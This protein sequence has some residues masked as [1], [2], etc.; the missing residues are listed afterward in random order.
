MATDQRE[1]ATESFIRKC[2]A[3][4]ASPWSL[5]RD[6]DDLECFLSLTE[7]MEVQPILHAMLMSNDNKPSWPS[8]IV[9]RL[10]ECNRSQ[11]VGFEFRVGE[12][13]KVLSRLA[14]AGVNGVLLKGIPLAHS[15]YQFPHHRPSSDVDILI[16]RESLETVNSQMREMGYQEVPDL[17]FGTVSQQ[18]QFWREGGKGFEHVFEFHTEMNNRPLLAPFGMEHFE[19]RSEVFTVGGI[20]L[21]GPKTPEAFV[22]AALHRLGHL[23]GDRRFLWLYDLKLVAE[24]MGEDDWELVFKIAQQAECRVLIAESI[25]ELLEAFDSPLSSE[26]VEWTNKNRSYS[27]EKSAYYIKPD[28]TRRSDLRVAILSLPSL[29]LRVGA[30]FQLAFPNPSYMRNQFPAGD[31]ASLLGLHWRRL[32]QVLSSWIRG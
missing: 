1:W 11:F 12:L 26:V 5:G 9:K 13:V 7:E 17:L 10:H 4:G 2:L 30:L 14:Q 15:H 16:D 23:P 18:K 29:L 3:E 24:A 6:P 22:L 8:V 27:G 25:G 32:R 31:K 21:R 28:R 20:E 19:T